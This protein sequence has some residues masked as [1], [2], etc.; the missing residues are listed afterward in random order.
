MSENVLETLMSLHR[1][2]VTKLRSIYT[3]L[4]GEEPPAK[5]H[6]TFLIPRVAYRIQERAYGSLSKKTQNRLSILAEDKTPKLLP[7]K[8]MPGTRILRTYKGHQLVVEVLDNG[9]SFDGVLYSSLSAVAKAI[10]GTHCSGPKFFD[11][12]CS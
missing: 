10:T 12:E 6:S 5:S 3:E 4:Y 7:K 8:M 1:M 9:F 2:S 11:G